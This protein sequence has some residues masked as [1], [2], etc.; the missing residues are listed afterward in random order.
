MPRLKPCQGRGCQVEGQNKCSG[1]SGRILT[2]KRSMSG[3]QA[4][5]TMPPQ[6]R[7][8]AASVVNTDF[9][10]QLIQRVR[11]QF[12]RSGRYSRAYCISISVSNPRLPDQNYERRS[13]LTQW[14]K[15]G[16]VGQHG[17]TTIVV[18]CD[19]RSVNKLVAPFSGNPVNA[20]QSLSPY[21]LLGFLDGMNGSVRSFHSSTCGDGLLQCLPSAL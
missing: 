2:A 7:T 9:F 20:S 3:V 5:R 4:G 1:L 18:S 12:D 19:W 14:L 8:F 13:L 6:S 10:G 11:G 16:P 21:I 15:L 17:K